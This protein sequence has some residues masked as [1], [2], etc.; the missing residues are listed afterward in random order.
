MEFAMLGFGLTWDPSP[1]SF[2]WFLL[3]GMRMS[4]LCLSHHC[5]LEIHS[6]SDFMGSPIKRNFASEW[7]VPSLIHIWFRWYLEET[8]NFRVNSGM[9]EDF[10]G[11]S[12]LGWFKVVGTKRMYFVCKKGVD[13]GWEQLGSGLSYVYW[14]KII[15]FCAILLQLFL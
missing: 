3:F 12:L 9:S 11:L 15:F 5:I 13:L 2:F 7:T 8:L 1:L 14:S 10:C 6:F 4:I